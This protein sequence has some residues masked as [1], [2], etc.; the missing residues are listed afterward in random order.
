[1]DRAS[2]PCDGTTVNGLHQRL[3]SLIDQEGPISVASFM[4]LAL[5]TYYAKRDP[6]GPDGDFL[7]APEVSQMFGELLGVWLIQAWNDQEKPPRP[8]LVELGP[9]KGSLM[10]DILRALKLA[11]Q[12]REQIEVVMVESS[13]SLSQVQ[14]E[15]LRPMD[16]TRRW[17][18]NLSEIPQDRPLF[19]VAN[20]FF[21]ALPIHQF[22][23]VEQGWVERLIG[24]GPDDTLRFVMAPTPVDSKDGIDDVAPLGGLREIAPAREAIMQEIAQRICDTSGAALIVD[25]GYSG[26]IGNRGTLQAVRQ[27]AFADVLL[28]PG[29]SDLSAHVD[30]AALV[31]AASRTGAAVAGPTT[32]GRFLERIGIRERARALSNAPGAARKAIARQTARLIDDQEMGSL[33]KVMAVLPSGAPKP[34]GF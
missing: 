19:L 14:Q 32:Q 24:I 34:V 18:Q 10:A 31:R 15:T 30:F 3:L 6:F 17:V 13:P 25:Y 9:G 28:N 7:T 27:H 1:M 12:L 8:L 16:I 33:F 26:E 22:V 29:E 4:T 5:Q 11:P 23:K 2:H 20:E 21:D